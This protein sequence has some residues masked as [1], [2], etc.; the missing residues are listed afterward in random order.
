MKQLQ[1][2][3]F[4]QGNKC[5]F[6]NHPIPK[7]QATVEHLDALSNG[8]KKS[9]ENAVVCCK[10]VN[11]WLGSRSVKEKFEVVLNHSRESACLAAI[12]PK[13]EAKPED[14]IAT[15]AQKLLPKVL[16]NLVGRGTARPKSM[17]KLK[18]SLATTFK[19]TSPKVIGAVLVLLKKK[20]YT[21]ENK[22]KVSYP[23]L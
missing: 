14:K 13:P 18:N 5:F 2:L 3:L 10:D 21:A 9:D 15:E 17:A 23:G 11:T 19:K 12:L 8:G 6:C 16:E 4:L 7:G 1:R 22:G 20:G